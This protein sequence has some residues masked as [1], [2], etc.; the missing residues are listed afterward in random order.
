MNDRRRKLLAFHD[1]CSIEHPSPPPAPAC[2]WLLAGSQV[3]ASLPDLSCF[4]GA[5]VLTPTAGCSL[6]FPQPQRSPST[7]SSNSSRHPKRAFASRCAAPGL[8]T[9]FSRP[10]HKPPGATQ[11]VPGTPRFRHECPKPFRFL[12]VLFHSTSF[13]SWLDSQHRTA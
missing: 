4:C 12:S 11:T 10:N 1:C 6:Y 2:G 5:R 7:P 9:L 13:P 3:V 8:G